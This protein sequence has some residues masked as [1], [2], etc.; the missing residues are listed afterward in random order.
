MTNQVLHVDLISLKPTT[1][2]VEQKDLITEAAALLSLEEVVGGGVIKA[3]TGSHFDLAVFFALTDFSA[4]EPFG[5]HPAYSRFLQGKV[6]PLLKAFAGTDVTID[7]PLELFEGY[8]ACLV[9]AAPEEAYDWEIR[10]KLEQWRDLAT[11]TASVLGMAIGER[12]RYR[13]F[14]MSF[15]D[16]P[17]DPP[18]PPNSRF[19]T[20]IVKGRTQPLA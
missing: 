7:K 8:G 17:F 18:R 4:L 12:Q 1:D 11:G 13:G 5:T 6:A 9:L 14:A 19:E 15:S 2:A 20:A 16:A 10:E 3:E